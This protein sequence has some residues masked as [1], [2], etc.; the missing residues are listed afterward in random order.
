VSVAGRD[1][2][3]PEA[4]APASLP[5]REH[6][7][8]LLEESSEFLLIVGGD[9]L[10]SYASPSA[11][12]FV[13][14]A[15]DGLVARDQ[16]GIV[17]PDE[18]A[19]LVTGCARLMR[20]PGGSRR[21]RVRVR[22]G[23]GE[24]CWHE[25]RA[26]KLVGGAAGLVLHARD[27][28]DQVRAEE[29]LRESEERFRSAFEHAPI[30][31]GLA[32]ADGRI[33]R[34][35]AAF[36][37]MVGRVAEEMVGLRLRELT[38]P[39][40]WAENDE[41]IRRLFAGEISGYEM[42][43]RYVHVDGHTVWGKLRVSAVHDRHGRPRYMIG[44]IIDITEQR[45]T[46]Q[47]LAHQVAHDP[48]TGLGNRWS[49][50]ERLQV[51][52]D[53]ATQHGDRVAVMFLDLDNFKVIN[54]SLG[55]DVGDQ[56]LITVG[57]RLRRVLR[58]PDTIARFGGDEFMIVCDPIRGLTSA[59]GLAQRFLAQVAQPVRLAHGEVFVTASIGI[60]L[61]G[62][63]ADT[64]ETLLRDADAAMYRAKDHGRARAEFFAERLHTRTVEHLETHNALNRA[65]TRDE[66]ELY[67]QPL[68]ELET[69][70]ITGF[71]AL[72]RWHHPHRGLIAP[73]EF[74]GHAEE[75]GLIVPIGAWALDH[76]CHQLAA[77]Q[78]TTNDPALTMNINL[79]PRQ[80]GEPSLPTRV[81]D[82][83]HNSGVHPGTVWLE[84]T[85]TTLMY[86]TDW[87]L[88][89]L[90]TLR[91]Q[92]VHLAVDDFGTGYS[93]LSHLKR[94]PIEALKIDQ[95]FIDGLGTDADD[96]AIVTAIISLAHALG[97]H[98]TAEGVETPHQLAELRTLGCELAQGHLFFPPQPAHILGDNPSAQ[99]DPWANLTHN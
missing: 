65:L 82:I 33:V 88:S 94:L 99:L 47:R 1:F 73:A 40:D 48:L 3:I 34:S 95:T 61:S 9:G 92:G 13:G 6:L 69:G 80:L 79:S 31:M 24:Y 72:L 86:D 50:L 15:P 89:A 27:I 36:A 70:R 41:N 85:E 81:A 91:A 77:W 74:I 17:H 54:D 93:S 57:E 52:L 28:E 78:T 66:F 55:H 37:H 59:M 42:E 19:R 87:A 10:I 96:T 97:L 21:F 76:A 22:R 38:H 53:R 64:P 98:A 62:Y 26:T 49:F 16:A 58:P 83:L 68:L 60:A 84:I 12:R 90:R 14:V 39:D 18:R 71:E 63:R 7:E 23:D 45:A 44:Q 46:R 51:A 11:G 32:G 20:G 35:N 8:A 56:L 25:V 30:G 43:K 4:T 29:A 2:S 67:Y 75:T 5:T